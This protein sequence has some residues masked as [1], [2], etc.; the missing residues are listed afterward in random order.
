MIP[1]NLTKQCL[2]LHHPNQ[3]FSNDAIELSSEFLRMFVLEARRRAAIE[4]ECEAEA[5]IVDPSSEI[6][7]DDDDN[8]T[9][10]KKVVKIRADHIAKIAAELLLD[11]S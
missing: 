8:G 6:M 7:T 11:L 2:Q 5:E 1:S 9:S 3:R 10:K 4:A